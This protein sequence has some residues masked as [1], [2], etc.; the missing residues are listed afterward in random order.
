MKQQHSGDM[1][2]LT[3]YSFAKNVSITKSIFSNLLIIIKQIMLANK[4]SNN[5]KT[6]TH[7][8]IQSP[9]GGQGVRPRP[10]PSEKSQ[11]YR[12]Y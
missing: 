12:V 2:V 3:F 5:Y 6:T 1:R 7:A 10:L 4:K 11:K 8:R 9:E